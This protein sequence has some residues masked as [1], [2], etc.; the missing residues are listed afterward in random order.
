[1]NALL[2][3]FVDE[4][5]KVGAF[6]QQDRSDNAYDGGDSTKTI[7]SQTQGTQ[8][9]AGNKGSPFQPKPVQRSVAGATPRTTPMDLVHHRMQTSGL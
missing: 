1:M 4:L 7:M 5:I 9:A 3:G 6:T 2:N 8:A